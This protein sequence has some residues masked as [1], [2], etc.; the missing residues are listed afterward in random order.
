MTAN[1]DSLEAMIRKANCGYALCFTP[2]RGGHKFALS[3]GVILLP[4]EYQAL[5]DR[6]AAKPPVDLVAADSEAARRYR[7]RARSRA[8]EADR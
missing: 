2:H 6:F 1:L 8:D 3:P 4:D 5:A 7:N